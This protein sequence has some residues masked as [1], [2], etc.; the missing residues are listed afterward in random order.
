MFTFD[1]GLTGLLRCKTSSTV[2]SPSY[3][4]SLKGKK[5]ISKI[6]YCN[7]TISFLLNKLIESTHYTVEP[8]IMIL[9]IT[10]CPDKR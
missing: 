7:Y 1:E 9:F 5:I 4:L 8:V 10:G 6:L 3:K 2:V